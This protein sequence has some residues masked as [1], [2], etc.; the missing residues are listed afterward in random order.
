MQNFLFSFSW[1]AM[2]SWR[3]DRKKKTTKLNI[4]KKC[5]KD[6]LQNNKNFG[7]ELLYSFYKARK[8]LTPPRYFLFAF[9]NL[10]GA[11]LRNHF[12]KVFDFFGDSINLPK[13]QA[14]P[15]A[16]FWNVLR[17][18]LKVL[19]RTLCFQTQKNRKI[20]HFFSQ[21]F[22]MSILVGFLHVFNYLAFTFKVKFCRKIARGPYEAKVFWVMSAFQARQTINC[23]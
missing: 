3:F 17:I 21:L 15:A 16:S 11:D 19:S 4:C 13:S 14:L 10:L 5:L 9:L 20:N 2:F 23:L 18:L 6:D 8:I 7:N 12:K 22:P 1:I